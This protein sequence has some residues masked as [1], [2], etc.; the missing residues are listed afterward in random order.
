MSGFWRNLLT[1]FFAIF[2][3]DALILSA[4]CTCQFLVTPFDVGL[5]T[6]KSDKYFQLAESAQIDFGIRS[7]FLKRMRHA[8]CAMVN[9]SQEIQFSKPIKLFDMVQVRTHIVAT[10]QQFIH[11]EHTYWV[12][13]QL[14][15]TV[16]IKAKLK[17]G[18]MTVP[19]N[20]LLDL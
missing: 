19:A 14:C 9:V 8:K 16:K 11:F 12:R 2:K 3:K 13:E 4:G 6:L 20:Q 17:A 1:V 5:K 7:G 18:R 10:D 15:S